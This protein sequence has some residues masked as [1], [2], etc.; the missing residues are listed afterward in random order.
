MR[1]PR[2]AVLL[3]VT[4]VTSTAVTF[5]T[6]G[7]LTHASD[8]GTEFAA[9]TGRIIKNGPMGRAERTLLAAAAAT[10]ASVNL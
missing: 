5:A 10:N 6:D 2:W 1:F 9:A 4:S 8:T 7:V 3:T